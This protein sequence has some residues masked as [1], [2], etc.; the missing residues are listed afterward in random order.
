[1]ALFLRAAMAQPRFVAYDT[2]AKAFLPAQPAQGIGAME[3]D[4]QN[5]L[6][7][8]TV[9]G[10]LSAKTGYTD[11]AQHTFAGAIARN[12][13][14]YG[15][16]LMRAQ[17]WPLD[18]WQQATALVRWAD[19]LPTGTPTVGQL[20]APA[21]LPAAPTQSREPQ[22]RS[23]ER[24]AHATLPFNSSSTPATVAGALALAVAAWL[25]G[26]G[27]RPGRPRRRR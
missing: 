14:R 1:M 21:I 23:E 10:A 17:R 15:V 12:G 11:A 5:E 27:V 19:A 8:T 2:A 4:N 20:A 16:I 18:Q 3:L 13:H 6:F 7:L 25:V 24:S 22:I 9:P 26:A